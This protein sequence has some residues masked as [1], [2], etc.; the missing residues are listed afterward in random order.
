[1]WYVGSGRG[2]LDKSA[3]ELA[4]DE[5]VTAIDTTNPER[6]AITCKNGEKYEIVFTEGESNYDD[7]IFNACGEEGALEE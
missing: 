6:I 7:L 3:R 5:D 4:N 1:M 2:S